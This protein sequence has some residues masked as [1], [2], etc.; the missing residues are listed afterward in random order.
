MRIFGFA[1]GAFL[2]W[3]VVV[4][5]PAAIASFMVALYGLYE[6]RTWDRN[7]RIQ[8][9]KLFLMGF[10][11]FIIPLFVYNTIVFGSPFSIGYSHSQTFR[12]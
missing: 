1:A 7:A 4:E 12:V 2:A 3:A 8:F 6:M 10:L 11:F 9:L 5:Y